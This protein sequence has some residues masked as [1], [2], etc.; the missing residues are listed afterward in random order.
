[1]LMFKMAES[2]DA[3]TQEKTANTFVEI[4]DLF[5]PFPYSI[6]TTQMF[7]SEIV[8]E[9]WE[10]FTLSEP[11]NYSKIQNGLN[12]A[13]G[14]LN[15]SY[16]GNMADETPVFMQT[17]ISRLDFFL[18][19]L[20]NPRDPTKTFQMT[21]GTLTPPF[22]FL[23]VKVLE[24]LCALLNTRYQ[25]VVDALWRTEPNV[26]STLLDILFFYK[27]N[28][29]LHYYVDQVI[30]IIMSLDNGDTIISVLIEKCKLL[31]RFAEAF[32]NDTDRTAGYMGHLAHLANELIKASSYHQQLAVILDEHAGWRDSVLPKLKEINHFNNTPIGGGV[33]MGMHDDSMGDSGGYMHTQQH[34]DQQDDSSPFDGMGISIVGGEHM[35]I[36][37]VIGEENAM[38]DDSTEHAETHH[39]N[40]E[41]E[42][43]QHQQQHHHEEHEEAGQQHE[44]EH[45]GVAGGEEGTSGAAHEEAAGAA[46]A[47]ADT[48]AGDAHS[49][50]AAGKEGEAGGAAHHGNEQ[51]ETETATAA[52]GGAAAEAGET[53]SEH[54][55]A[56]EC[57][58]ADKGEG[59]GAAGGATTTSPGSEESNNESNNK[60]E[61]VATSS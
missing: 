58:T 39:N 19:L 36:E 35:S 45:E 43:Q 46:P 32:K 24:F 53:H 60:T 9:Q 6:L 37:K 44:H 29:T 38:P 7:H 5:V 41:Q 10:Q 1:L 14:I 18:E 17:V 20:K 25:S 47:E 33:G 15:L 3:E 26:F 12:V 8:A 28:N 56:G 2:E 52:A 59:Q 4:L 54:A 50:A 57:G 49:A 21:Y 48:H 27:W 51:H 40:E 23:R 42:Q 61:E 30:T 16:E 55:G 22:G 31:E 11:T 34:D 13:I